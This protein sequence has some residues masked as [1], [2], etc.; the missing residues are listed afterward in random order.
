MTK[1]LEHSNNVGTAW[2]ATKLG[3]DKFFSY[4]KAFGVG[5]KTGIDLQG[6]SVGVF[7]EAPSKMVPLDLATM[8][9]GQGFSTTALKMVQIAAT[10]A[11]GGKLTQPHFV[12]KIA[13]GDRDI[14]VNTPRPKQVIKP[15]TAQ[16]L[17]EMMINAVVNGEARRLVLPGYRIAGKTG[18]AQVPIAGHYDA[19]KTIASF[20]G[21]APAEDP[22][23]V[24]IVKYDEPTTTPHGATTA[25]PTFMA[26]TKELFP[27]FGLT[28]TP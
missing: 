12:T 6:E 22:K 11:N 14:A 28:P 20:V 25:V 19:N 18:T 3:K 5:E 27:Y 10:I 13:D 26:I 9:F 17:T 21:F 8:G 24:M 7:Y 4:A 15:A 2:L 1:V 23:F 16:S